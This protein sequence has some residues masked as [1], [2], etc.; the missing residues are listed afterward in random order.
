MI[1]FSCEVTNVYIDEALLT[2][3]S[4]TEIDKIEFKL[5]DD[6]W[7]EYKSRINS[8]SGELD[9]SVIDYDFNH[10]VKV[11]ATS[12]NGE[13]SDEVTC[14]FRTFD[15]ARMLALDEFVFGEPMKYRFSNPNID[16]CN[17]LLTV[18][19]SNG[20]YILNNPPI[21][22]G[23]TDYTVNPDQDM[24][25]SIYKLFGFN[26]Y[27]YVE[28]ILSTETENDTY[29]A[30]YWE[31]IINLT[32]NAKTVHVGVDTIDKTPH[33]AQIFI[34]D[35]EKKPRRSVAWVGVDSKIHRTI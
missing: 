13:V 17:I 35:N 15:I 32:G 28:I 20:T 16:K 33:R 12:M 9:L 22:K 1:N 21:D 3:N 7:D 8:T 4:D 23:A 14:S 34:G 24:W 19:K 2:W 31:N 5:N 29:I 18:K 11:R 25:D 27:Q 10:T 30:G 6:P 26:D